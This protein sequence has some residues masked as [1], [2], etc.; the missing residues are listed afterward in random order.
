MLTI[1]KLPGLS[2]FAQQ[3]VLPT[4]SLGSADMQ[5]PF[6]LLPMPGEKAEFQPLTV[7][8]LV[9][10][11]MENYKA[12]YD[13]ITGLAFPE[14]H[15]QYTAFNS[16]DQIA[17]SEIK[18]NTSDASLVVLGNHNNPIQTIQFYDCWPE[19]LQSLTFLSNS[20]DVQYL[21]GSVTF[22]YSYYKFV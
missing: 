1:Q 5:N 17:G 13:W 12:I 16:T 19:S 2:Y 15:E 8:F 7:D 14:K 6:V 10:E 11:K 21:V 22:R 20:Q 9:D 18:K 3:V 4:L